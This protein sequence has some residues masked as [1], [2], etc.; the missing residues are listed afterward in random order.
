MI[1]RRDAGIFLAAGGM[2]LA[3]WRTAANAADPFT[4]TSTMFKDG[5]MMPQK[6]TNKGT[7]CSGENISPQLSWSNPPDGTKS[8]AITLV[9]PE[10][11]GGAGSIHWVAY[12]I[13]PNVTGF[14]EGEASKPSPKFVGGKGGGGHRPLEGPCAGP[15]RH[16][17]IR[18]S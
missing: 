18:S 17:T 3:A 6:V 8:F 5:T 15:G 4:L 12:G 1:K 10:A 2:A 14:E 9:D 11:R 13:A 7:N 16:T